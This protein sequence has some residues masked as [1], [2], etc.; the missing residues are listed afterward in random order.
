MEELQRLNDLPDPNRI[1]AGQ[2]LKVPSVDA[3]N[4]TEAPSNGSP[5]TGSGE[6]TAR[7][8]TDGSKGAESSPLEGLIEALKVYLSA[9]AV[10]IYPLG[11]IALTIQIY[12]DPVFPS[13][14]PYMAWYAASLVPPLTVLSTAAFVLLS[15]LVVSTSFTSLGMLFFDARRR[16]SGDGTR[17]GPVRHEK[18]LRVVSVLVLVVVVFLLIA[19]RFPLLNTNPDDVGWNPYLWMGAFLSAFGAGIYAG[20][21]KVEH[22]GEWLHRGALAAFL[23]AVIAAILIASTQYPAL[24][25]A[26]VNSVIDPGSVEATP[27]QRHELLQLLAHNG[28]RWY[29]Y[30]PATGIVSIPDDEVG[31]VLMWDA[32]LKRSYIPPARSDLLVVTG[33]VW[34]GPGTD[35]LPKPG[36]PQASK[37]ANELMYFFGATSTNCVETTAISYEAQEMDAQATVGCSFAYVDVD[38]NKWSSQKDMYKF[39]DLILEQYPTA[40]ERQ[41]QGGRMLRYE[42]S[43]GHPT[44]FWTHE[45]KLMSGVVARRFDSEEEDLD[46]WLHDAGLLR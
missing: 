33:A 11:F 6:D 26:E 25:Q 3:A 2:V 40:K 24:P 17:A 27:G 8:R 37:A 21:N 39:Y 34:V 18:V 7:K 45:T 38:Y 9:V 41:W 31:T 46:K 4:D 1:S 44:I 5:E 16:R 42:D 15:S 23:G 10:T 20:Y 43:L 29:G 36:D 19:E 35:Q 28:G 30:S 32:A 22:P 14:D 13:D 12:R